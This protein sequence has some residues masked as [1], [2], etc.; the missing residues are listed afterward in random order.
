LFPFRYN[1]QT[2]IQEDRGKDDENVINWHHLDGKVCKIAPWLIEPRRPMGCQYINTHNDA[3]SRLLNCNTNIL[4]GDTAQVYYSTLY[5]I[6]NNQKED[7]ERQEIVNHSVQRRIMRIEEEVQNGIRGA[8]EVQEG[9]IEGLCRMLGAM[10]ASTSRFV[11]GTTMAHLMVCQGG[12]RFKI[13]HSTGNLLI[14]Q[15]EATLEGRN[16]DVRLRTNMLNSEKVIWPD[17]SADDYLHRPDDD[18]FTTMCYYEYTM[19]YKKIYKTFREMN[20]NGHVDDDDEPDPNATQCQ[21]RKFAFLPT[22]PGKSFSNL[23][24]LKI[25][26]IPKITLPKPGLCN[27]E[28]LQLNSANP[29]AEAL[30]SR[31]YYAKMSLL[32][33]YPFRSLGELKLNGSYW[34]KFNKERKL[35]ILQK[36]TNS[37]TSITTTFWP[38]GFEI[39]QNMQDRLTM[40]K[41]VKRARDPITKL[42]TCEKPDDSDNNSPNSNATTNDKLPDILQYC[43]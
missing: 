25:P 35:W 38:K 41:Q 4:I 1:K 5:N 19:W 10:N 21:K 31:E 27:I 28:E 26:V 7:S 42:T 18:V 15:L 14:T 12:T 36:D 24:K 22:H 34:D 17:S 8:D 9:F 6:K 33:F 16:V 13:S 29:S 32:M 3:L 39:L 40:E 11:V 30:Q 20:T 2:C 37:S 23:A 43:R